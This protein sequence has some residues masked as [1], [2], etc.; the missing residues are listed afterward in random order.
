MNVSFNIDYHSRWGQKLLIVGSIPQL[1]D[2]DIRKAVEMRYIDDNTWGVKI[3]IS[4]ETTEIT[5]EYVLFEDGRLTFESGSEKHRIVFEGD[6]D[7]YTIYDNWQTESANYVFYSSA[8]QKNIFLHH[9]DSYPTNIEKTGNLIINVRAP[10]LRKSQRLY[11]SGNQEILGDWD[12]KKALPMSY[13]GEALWQIRIDDSLISTDLEYKFVAI[14]SETGQDYWDCGENR[15][16]LLPK[17]LKKTEVEI[18]N[19]GE[20]RDDSPLW[21]GCGTVVPVFSLRSDDSFGIGDFMDLRKMIDWCA[22][23]NQHILQ[24]LPINDTTKDY[25]KG[26]S[27]PY[28]AISIYAL[29]PIYLSIK[30]IGKLKDSKRNIF[31]EEKRKQLNALDCLDYEETIKWKLSYCREYFKENIE[32]I[33]A[34]EGFNAF[35]DRNERW[36]LP[37]SA[38]SYLRDT[39]G[40]ADYRQWGEYSRYDRSNIEVLS[41]QSRKAAE[42]MLFFQ[43]LQYE[44][45]K[46]LTEV[47]AYARSKEVILKGDLPIGVNRLSVETWTE[48]QYFNLNSQAGAPPDDFSVKGQNWGFPTYNWGKMEE[49][50]FAWWKCRFAKLEEYFDSFRID[51]ILGF[52]RIWEIPTEYVRGLCGH[53]NPAI[54]LSIEEIEDKG[55]SFDAK[56]FTTPRINGKFLK[57]IFGEYTDE[58]KEKYLEK[59]DEHYILKS[60][61]DTQTKISSHLGHLTDERSV[62]ITNGLFDICEEVLFLRDPKDKIKFHPRISAYMSYAYKELSEEQRAIFDGIYWDF[63]YNRHNDFWKNTALKRLKPLV[64]HT[65][66]LVC[67]EDLGMIPA[68]VPEV[69]RNLHILSLDIERMP[70][71]I[72]LEFED[73]GKLPYMSVCSPSTHDMSPIREWW[74]E[75]RKRT[76][77]YFRNV[78]KTHGEAPSECSTDIADKIIYGNLL[79][80]SMLAIIP[81]Q[82]WTTTDASSRYE[83][84]GSERINIPADPHHYWRYRSHISVE[85]LQRCDSLNNKI[86]TMIESSGR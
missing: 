14:D 49:D 57:E 2:S 43:F 48:P 86:L 19:N 8:F 39:Y 35:K 45:D 3:E 34:N 71:T 33:K 40:T 17:Y 28:S 23:T 44:L 26:D 15:K 22:Q 61:Y 64:S 16:K 74:E 41:T 65:K 63:F 20:F 54:P 25:R 73:L 79:S 55:L 29:H 37:Y 83:G 60:E 46:Q 84:H 5:Y 13:R 27:Y 7:S 51:H 72:N 56:R 76:Q 18:I 50:G 6:I 85:Q 1:G 52:F 82:D 32:T 21:R 75:D 59:D 30:S 42:E 70:K 38:Y 78:L 11:I 9:P 77:S 66:M 68:S 81:L 47:S 69:M 80:P 67:G 62:R 24:I 12:L 58:V 10:K 4:D 31:Y 53:F 36:L